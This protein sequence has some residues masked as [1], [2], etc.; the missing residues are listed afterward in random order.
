MRIGERIS[1]AWDFLREGVLDGLH[2]VRDLP[3]VVGGRRALIGVGG[4]LLIGGVTWA[5]V[6]GPLA[7]DE[8][9]TG[10]VSEGG[11]KIV[12]L[13]TLREPAEVGTLG[14]PLVATRN[15]T[16]IPGPDPIA[17]AAAVA[18]ATHPPGATAKPV[19]AVLTVD[20]EEWQAGVA[21]SVLTGPPLRAPLLLSLG[22]SLTAPGEDAIERLN[23]RGGGP[24]DPAVYAIGGGAA[25]EGLETREVSGAGPAEIADAVDRLRGDLISG[26]PSSVVIASEE[27]AGYAMPAAAWAARSGHPVFFTGRNELPE[28]TIRALTRHRSA[29]VYVLGPPSVISEGVRRQIA[30]LVPATTRVGAEGVV[31]NAIEFARYADSEFGWNIND[32]G[33]GMV[34]ANADRPLD[35][36]A[37]AA[38]SASGQWGPLLLVESPDLIP[39]ELRSFLLDIKPGYRDD[40]TRA[41]YNRLWLLGDDSAIG[42][43]MQ[44]EL[45]ELAEITEIG[46]GTGGIVTTPGGGE[47]AEPGGAEPEVDPSKLN[48]PRKEKKP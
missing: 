46:R 1:G 28:A 33:H 37:G 41:V 19:E 44:A 3:S 38:L 16:R 7:G 4:L 10:V 11:D 13:N 29:S 24:T 30:K 36:A 32:P 47:V 2:W 9:G 26:K 18:L 8:D 22:G 5:A 34:I 27:E 25:P 21:A 17:D 40:P 20:A 14:F 48:R 39:P 31:A 35:A 6:D 45:D 12:V 42:A 43:E 15:T 23:P